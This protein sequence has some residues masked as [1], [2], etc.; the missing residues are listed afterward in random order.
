MK[1]Q[2]ITDLEEKEIDLFE[3][4]K[5]IWIKRVFVLK[6]SLIG[7]IFGLIIA[8]S[9]PEEY[10]TEVKL[11]P[12]N[13]QINKSGQL[14]GLA[15]MAGFN[16]GGVKDPDALSVDLY[17]DIVSS[18][19]FLLELVEFPVEI[20]TKNIKVTFYEY[21]TEYQKIPWWSYLK[22][23]PSRALNWVLSHFRD[24]QQQ[25]NIVID[26]FRLTEKQ[27]NF[28]KRVNARIEVKID[29]KSGVIVISLTMQDPLIS[30]VMADVIV[31]KLQEYITDYRTR[32]A[33]LDLAFSERLYA[34][35]DSSY[36]KARK[37]YAAYID[38]NKNVV[39]AKS[40]TE[41]ERLR[42]EVNLAF[43]VFTQMAQQLESNKIK[44]QEETPVYVVIE[45]ARIPVL[46]IKPNKLKIL[47]AFI[48]MFG[49]GS[50]VKI[51]SAE[52]FF[53]NINANQQ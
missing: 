5:K 23:L 39:Y 16:M 51:I 26:P 27:E 6:I 46:A 25:E 45:P 8:F 33:K 3:L 9:I 31:S 4:V 38:A 7:A 18:A 44:V 12:E 10:K 37:A 21:M 24:K 22:I 48:L 32:K 34:E 35:S 2:N 40:K 41:E 14:S 49:F 42:N 20:K 52:Y 53:K 43:N 50:V 19:P 15:A 36:Y 13:A 1:Q 47:I 29:K 17:P 30:A 11:S 28:I